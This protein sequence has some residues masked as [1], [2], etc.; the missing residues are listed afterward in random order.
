MPAPRIAII[1]GAAI[2]GLVALAAPAFAQTSVKPCTEYSSNAS[3]ITVYGCK[4]VSVSA[5]LP[6][7]GNTGAF[8][9][10]VPFSPTVQAAAYAQGAAIGNLATLA[11]FRLAAQPSGILGGLAFTWVDGQVIA[12]TEYVFRA[13]PTSSTCTDKSAFVLNAADLP[14]L[15]L[16]VALTPVVQQNETAASAFQQLAFPISNG[17][18]PA[19]TNLYV[20]TVANAAVTP[21]STTDVV[22]MVS[23]SQ[24]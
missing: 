3:G 19:G 23:V 4:N 6:V 17:D 5:P 7:T 22:E 9:I 8:D 20:C 24:D 21:G 18:S 13:N 11:A 15:V 14:K 10:N 16:A 12:V 2:V 1:A